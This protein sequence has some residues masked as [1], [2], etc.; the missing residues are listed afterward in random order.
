MKNKNF[1]YFAFNKPY[2]CLSQF[3]DKLNRKTLSDFGVIPKGVYPIGR[4]DMD[5]EGL[6]ILSDD[7]QLVDY[8]LN[9]KNFHEKE[10]LVQVEGIPSEE[11]LNRFKE[12]VIIEGRKTL[13]AKIEI[14]ATPNIPERNPPIRQRKNIPTCW[15][16]VIITEGR[17]RQVR[18]MTAAIG[19]PTLRLIRVRI[20]NVDIGDL[21]L[22]E[23]RELTKNEIMT[24]KK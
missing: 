17:N 14:I 3:T 4:L 10:Y 22:G 1:R 13:P 7:K 9:P 8:L 23:I 20:K 18:K 2:G 5:S 16:K 15:L 6:L 24:L 12:G 11:Q 19:H 21:K